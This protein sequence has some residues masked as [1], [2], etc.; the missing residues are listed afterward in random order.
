M[1]QVFHIIRREIIVKLKSRSFYL[2]ALVTPIL[3]VLPVLFSVFSGAR[4]DSSLPRYKVGVISSEFSYDTLEYRN[5]KFFALTDQ[6][7]SQVRN[8]SFDYAGFIGVVDLHDVSFS[9][10]P[11]AMQ[12]QLY[13]PE[14][15]AVGVEPYIH[16]IESFVNSEFVYQYGKR[17]NFDAAELLNLTNFAKLSVTFS[18]AYDNHDE[19]N[20]AKVLAFGLGILLYV[21]FILF[22]N[23]IVKS[24]SEEKSNKLA[25]VLSMFVKPSVL[26]VGKILGLSVASLVQ[27]LVWILA[28]TTY[29]KLAIVIGSNLHYISATDDVSNLD[30]GSLLFS[31]SMMSWLVLFFAMG[32]LLNGSLSTIFA[33][34]SSGRGSAVPMV[35]SNI[36][37]LLSIYFCMFSAANPSSSITTFASYFPLTSYLVIPAVLPYGVSTAHI[38]VSALC[39]VLV[40]VVLLYFSGKLY[41]KFLV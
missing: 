20:K 6:E 24:V 9:Q 8:G 19:T 3:F 13:V 15:M 14:G 22:N 23:N 25:E 17:N 39:L 10:T 41:R 38:L 12:I 7:V 29:T 11:E 32:F 30:F 1:K 28:F 27:L 5:I 40:S 26:I 18:Q 33:I 21:M 31:G 16:D 34:C 36:L 37:N 35:L 2:F 4:G